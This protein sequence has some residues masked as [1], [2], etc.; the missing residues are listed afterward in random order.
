MQGWIGCS[1]LLGIPQKQFS[2]SPCLQAA[3]KSLKL[4]SK[5]SIT[6]IKIQLTFHKESVRERETERKRKKRERERERE[7]EVVS[8]V[9]VA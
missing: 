4:Q 2:F 5:K 6:S 3:K 1:R 9:L 7:R 8:C